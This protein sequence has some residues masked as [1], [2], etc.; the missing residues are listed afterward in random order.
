M[1]MQFVTIPA[2]RFVMGSCLLSAADKAENASRKLLN[3]APVHP[4][5]SI[6][7][8]VDELAASDESPQ[9]TVHFQHSFQLSRR[10][11]T[12]RQF[13]LFIAESGRSNFLTDDFISANAYG[14][15]APVVAVSWEQ[16]QAFIAWLNRREGGHHYRLPTEAEW[17]YAARAGTNTAWS[18]KGRYS[19][20]AWYKSNSDDHPHAVGQKKPNPWG[21][22]DMHG[23]AWE[24]V[25]D[26]YADDFYQRSG[27]EAPIRHSSGIMRAVRGGGWNSPSEDLRT[28]NRGSALPDQ[29]YDFVGFRLLKE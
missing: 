17:E 1:A 16:V 15:D 2:G 14:D 11:V 26:W 27:V 7:T 10:E 25:A 4:P 18:F 6:G 8:Q 22:Y 5:C 20:Y 28:A 13:K 21:L 24:W 12:L 29:G 19:D 3:L 23:N 9:H